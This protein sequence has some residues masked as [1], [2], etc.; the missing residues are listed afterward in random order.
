[1][2]RFFICEKGYHQEKWIL[3]WSKMK[4]VFTEVNS[5]RK[6]LEQIIRQNE[7]NQ[8]PYSLISDDDMDAFITARHFIFMTQSL[9]HANF[10]ENVFS[11]NDDY[12]AAGHMTTLVK[13]LRQKFTDHS[14]FLDKIDRFER[15][16]FKHPTIW[17]FTCDYFL[18]AIVNHAIQ[19]LDTEFL[20]RIGFILRQVTHDI[21]KIWQQQSHHLQAPFTVYRKQMMS[22]GD[23][24][25]LQ[26][27]KSSN[28]KI[29]QKQN[30]RILREG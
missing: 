2:G 12:N 15:E 10:F 21:R 16:C 20:F 22:E 24:F 23:F 19:T 4:G 30:S 5:I 13:Y 18:F 25:K 6:A 28:G 8:I 29:H 17:W 27:T 7:E 14:V 26:Q 1:M 9:L 11:Q 3:E